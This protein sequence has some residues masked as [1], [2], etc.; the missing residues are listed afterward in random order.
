MTQENTENR[1]EE[2]G[3]V[4]SFRRSCLLIGSLL[5]AVLLSVT[6]MAPFYMPSF[7]DENRIRRFHNEPADSLDVV[8]IGSSDVYTGFSAGLAYRD[9]GIRSY[10]YSISGESCLMWEPMVKDILKTQHPDVILIETYGAGY[11]DKHLRNTAPEAFKLL[12][13]MPLSMDKY[14]EAKRMAELTDKSDTLSYLFPFIKYHSS[15][16]SY[17]R[18]LKNYFF[19]RREKISPLKGTHNKTAVFDAEQLMDLSEVDDTIPLSPGSEKA[20]RE[21]IEYC[22]TIDTRIVFVKFPTLAKEEGSFMYKKH[23]RSNEAGRIAMENGFDFIPLQKYAHEMGLENG[24][25][26][27]DYGHANV[28]GQKKITE[29]LCTILRDEYGLPSGRIAA[30]D[31]TRGEWDESAAAYNVYYELSD[32][33]IREGKKEELKDDESTLARVRKIMNAEEDRN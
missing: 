17:F 18:N 27:Y 15:Y 13:T 11:S 31:E 2:K 28:Y 12:D 3:P 23:L 9:Y 1:I 30:S 22:K 6:L 8:I 26:F 14:R 32:K 19:L 4:R 33:E 7:E 24:D 25:D 16:G 29:K 21:F 10:P 5:I 20:L